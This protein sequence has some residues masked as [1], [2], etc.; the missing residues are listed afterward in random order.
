MR[1]IRRLA[2]LC[3]APGL[4]LRAYFRLPK[5]VKGQGWWQPCL[6]RGRVGGSHGQFG[7]GQFGPGRVSQ[8]LSNKGSVSYF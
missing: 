5:P 4:G 7:H 3:D 6:V 8:Y 1:S 2:L